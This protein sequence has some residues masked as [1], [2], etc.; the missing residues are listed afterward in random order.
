MTLKEARIARGLT[1]EQL[2]ERSGVT[3][4]AISAIELGTVQSP[5]WDTVASICA[6]LEVKPEDVFPVRGRRVEA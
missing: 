6:V 3:Q 4:T 5:S 2:A 1:Q